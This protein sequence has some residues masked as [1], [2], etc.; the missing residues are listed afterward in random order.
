MSS[1]PAIA[2]ENQSS[3]EPLK[4]KILQ[5]PVRI[6]EQVWA[7]GTVPLVSIWC[8]TYNHANFIRDAIQGFLMQKTTFPVEIFIHDDASTDGTAEI[9][10]EYSNKYSDIP[11]RCTFL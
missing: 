9:I 6:I 5:K 1:T 7:E 4:F 10:Q 8:I 11:V 2:I 3:A